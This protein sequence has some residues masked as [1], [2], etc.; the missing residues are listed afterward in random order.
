MSSTRSSRATRWAWIVSLVAAGGAAMVLAF[1]LAITTNNR[2]FYE[3]H[4]T[5]LLWVNV[6]IAALLA[7]VIAFGVWR[8]VSRI[9]SG[10]FGS[11]LLVKI[12]AVFALV[13]VLPGGLIYLVS[14]QFV[15]RSI[16][17][18]FDVQVEGALDAGLKLGRN[19]LESLSADL[20]QKTRL[21]ADRSLDGSERVQ[22]VALERLREQLGARSVAL[23]GSGG[24]VLAVAWQGTSAEGPRQPERPTPAQLRAARAS[25]AIA[26]LEGLDEEPAA[27]AAGRTPQAPNARIQALAWVPDRSTQLDGSDRFLQVIQPLPPQLIGN[28]LA[29]QAAYR[30]YQQRALARDGLRSMYIGT[31]TLTLVLAVF[32]ALLMSAAL[33]QQIARPL[34][35]LAEGV[36]RIAHGDLRPAEVFDSRDE[37]GGLTRQFADM[38]QQLGD[39][40]ALVQRSL[41]EI[42]RSKTHLQTILD[43]LTAGVIVLDRDSRIESVNPGATR[44][45][46]LPL[47]A[48]RGHPLEAV[49]GLETFAQAVTQR[50]ESHASEPEPGERDQWQDSL[51]LTGSDG[52]TQTLLMRGAGLPGRARLVVFDDI[53]E[54]V[55]AQR[56]AAW[57]EVARRLAH[58]IKNPLTPI[59]LSAERLRHKLESRLEGS[60]QQMLVRSVATIVNQVQAMEQ[61]VNEFRDYARMPAVV[62]RPLDLN[63][64]IGEVLGLYGTLIES[65][66]LRAECAG[67]LPQILGDAKLLR[68]VIHNL[69]QNGLDAVVDQGEGQVTVRTDLARYD[70]GRARAVRLRVIDTGAGFP[71]KVLKRAF[72]PYV[73]TKSKG[74]GLGLAV[75]KKIVEEHGARIRLTNVEVPGFGGSEG[76]VVSGAQVSISFSKLAAE[77]PSEAAPARSLRGSEAS[78]S[79]DTARAPH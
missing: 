67:D 43:N 17:S 45:L 4:Y 73:T 42:E 51:D 1:V 32:G 53:T 37:L 27:G 41:V 22:A 18:W 24:Q 46:R 13:G 48:H 56:T 9:W 65:G 20:A 50:F 10:K 34:L 31:L 29:V 72:E 47:S 25:G 70:D 77:E 79:A 49:P 35:M 54:V 16:E 30:E 69:V 19:T 66:R 60:D 75:V 44:I 2:V 58:E 61:L 12:A 39:A 33:G 57:S 52:A 38:T 64:L 11:R 71:E 14:Y 23:L 78:A 74:T 7:V 40:R 8:L 59:Q 3:R 63:A 15:T 6:G 21:A 28:A 76:A 68:Q 36:R 55:S 5:W 26:T 62:L